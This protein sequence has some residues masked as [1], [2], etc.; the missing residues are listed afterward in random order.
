MPFDEIEIPFN[1][2]SQTV[3]SPKK[4]YVPITPSR[5]P[6]V[7]STSSEP[8]AVDSVKVEPPVL[9]ESTQ[10]DCPPTSSCDVLKEEQPSPPPL[11][12]AR[13]PQVECD[14]EDNDD[15]PL[16]PPPLT[17][18]PPVSEDNISPADLSSQT[19]TQSGLPILE[20]AINR[21]QLSPDDSVSSAVDDTT[22]HSTQED[23]RLRFGN[24][25]SNATNPLNISIDET[26]ED[27]CS[28]S[29]VIF[30]HSSCSYIWEV[31]DFITR[32]FLFRQ[33]IQVLPLMVKKTESCI[34]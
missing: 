15:E 20:C 27:D 26:K 11:E 28:V 23:D 2:K 13:T 7:H 8:S 12:D 1:S 25:S 21:P 30:S 24:A 10:P 31:F 17:P 22:V 18:A 4:K 3:G 6:V 9:V 29:H 34:Q 14:Q 19:V 32:S 16:A 5:H 33:V